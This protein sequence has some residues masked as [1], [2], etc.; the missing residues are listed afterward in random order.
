MLILGAFVFFIRQRSIR[1]RQM[2]RQ[3]TQWTGVQ[4]MTS[5]FE[6]RAVMVTPFPAGGAGNMGE[7]SPGVTFGRSQA[8]ALA[9]SAPV[10]NMPQAVPSSY[11]NPAAAAA[12]AGATPTALV[13]YE[14]IPTLPDEL[15]IT[16]GELVR[17]LA[18]YDDGWALCANGRGDQ[19]MV[20]LECLDRST[21][22][23]QQLQVV[24]QQDFRNSRRTSSL[25]PAGTR[26]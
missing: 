1:N 10:P 14:F 4:P 6:P 25:A 26:Y 3:T 9:A 18:E 19:G 5:S 2:R 16:T 23:G 22:A 21:S 8:L 15:S 20:P 24:E 11:N 17:L 7:T 13:R 12:P